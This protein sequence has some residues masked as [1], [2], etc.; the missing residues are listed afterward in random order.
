[1]RIDPK[2]LGA[3]YSAL[4][5]RHALRQLDALTEWDL[6][7]FESTTGEGRAFMQA[8]VAARLAGSAGK[9]CWSITQAGK[10][11]S[12]A[13]AAPVVK[14]NRREAWRLFRAG[15]TTST[16]ARGFGQ[17]GYRGAFWQHA[18]AGSGRRP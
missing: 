18:E 7:R 8:L 4:P 5:V 15:W 14:R 9:E 12:S 3:G 13:T 10:S 2:G 16:E 11:L 6:R 1:M 17:G